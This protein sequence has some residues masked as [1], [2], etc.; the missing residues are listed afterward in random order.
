M[1]AIS[2]IE[3]TN[4]MKISDEKKKREEK[5]SSFSFKTETH[6][7]KGHHVVSASLR[8]PLS[9]TPLWCYYT[10]FSF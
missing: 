1:E 5:G 6:A 4:Q 7:K 8:R 10:S 3:M 9:P 2:K